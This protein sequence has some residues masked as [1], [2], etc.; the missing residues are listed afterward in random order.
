MNGKGKEY[1]KNGD[2]QFEGDYV[3]GRRWNGKGYNPK[4]N[5]DFS[6]ILGNG[7]WLWKRI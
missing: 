6:I 5:E 4:G 1:Y 2:L 3:N 7:E